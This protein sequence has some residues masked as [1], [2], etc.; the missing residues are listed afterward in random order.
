MDLRAYRRKRNFRKTPE[1]AG[2][3]VSRAGK[4]F[5]FVVHKH[6]ARN[7]HYDLR[8]EM[9][10]VLASWAV[11][12]GP[13][14][15]P[16]ERRL[17]VQVEDHPIEYRTF[18][19]NIPEGQYG[20]GAVLLW[21]RGSWKPEG[22]PIDGRRNGKL[23]FKLKGEKLRG[24][25]T[26]V[27]MNGK[28]Q[29]N[30]KNWLLIKER[31]GNAGKIDIENTSPASV[32]S[33]KRIEELIPDNNERGRS[34]TRRPSQSRKREQ[35]STA[36]IKSLNSPRSS[37]SEI[38]GIK[39]TNP[40]RILYPDQGITKL[41][42]AQYYE[43]IADWIM[44]HIDGR[45]LTLLRCPEGHK[46]QCFYQRH[47][48]QAL[49]PA[50][51]L[52]RVREKKS[53]AEYLYIDSLPGLIALA[54]MG[55]L[56]LH[57]WGARKERINQPDQLIFDLDPDPTVSWNTLK[58][59]ALMF[60]ARLSDLGLPAFLKTTGGKGLHVVVPITPKQDWSFAK[61]F[62]RTMAQ[63]IVREYPDRYT[64]TMS[65]TKRKGKIFIDYLRN[66]QTATTVCA[67]STRARSGAPVSLPLRWED[68]KKD[69]RE[70]FTVKNVPTR[71]IQL[72]ID[73]WGT[74]ESARTGITAQMLKQL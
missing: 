50:I 5:R 74:F 65:R 66:S 23:K 16:K 17:A 48:N 26:L 52:V 9:N 63:S 32:K 51:R 56:E 40:D 14:L 7:L 64:A 28:R 45:P 47:V 35:A 71:L 60:R 41:E 24:G 25:W 19:G 58:A 29:P 67:Y 55:V 1:P 20:A 62:A 44:P 42:L 49:D 18:E 2:K 11:P 61:E 12:K 73:P 38:A 13:S 53:E 4:E 27:R 68:L 39:L 72:R 54:Q 6:A 69:V 10:G 30:G 36:K 33:G 15:D 3:S 8:L 46:K 31:D 43:N 59:A 34:H 70:E 22:D 57:T 37:D 21:D